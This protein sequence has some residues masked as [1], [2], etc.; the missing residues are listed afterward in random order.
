MIIEC[1]FA[2]RFIDE[3]KKFLLAIYVPNEK[4]VQPKRL[5]EKLV[6]ARGRFVSNRALFEE[7]MKT[8]KSESDIIDHRMMSAIKDIEVSKWIY[9]R[10]TRSYSVFIKA[11]GSYGYGV[12]G[13]TDRIRDITGG[14]GLLIETGVVKL[15]N[16]FV[17]DGLV[18]NFLH[19][20][21]NYRQSFNDIYK[22]LRKIG[23]FRTNH[24]A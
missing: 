10:D 1:D 5:I 19:L 8:L 14:T 23:K 22:E 13:L 9:L 15:G 20:G 21:K 12:L 3:Y 2:N 16:N 18:S 11:D 6:L 17:C 4:N 7:Y 24:L